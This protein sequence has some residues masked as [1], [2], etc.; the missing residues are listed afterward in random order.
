MCPQKRKKTYIAY[1]KFGGE[2]LELLIGSA[3]C[4]YVADLT[5]INIRNGTLLPNTLELTKFDT[6]RNILFCNCTKRSSEFKQCL[7]FL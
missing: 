3:H 2:S 5:N 1:C 6:L 7:C 4:V